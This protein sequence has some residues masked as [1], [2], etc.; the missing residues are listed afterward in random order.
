MPVFILTAFITSESWNNFTLGFGTEYSPPRRMYVKFQCGTC[1]KSTF[2]YFFF[3]HLIQFSMWS[4]PCTKYMNTHTTLSKWGY[5]KSNVTM[6]SLPRE[7]K[8][9]QDDWFSATLHIMSFASCNLF[10]RYPLLMPNA[11]LMSRYC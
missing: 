7:Q 8:T 1:M 6:L 4:R 11:A 5:T 2:G 10:M 9:M 3:T